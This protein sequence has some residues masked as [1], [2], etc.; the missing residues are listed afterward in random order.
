MAPIILRSFS[1]RLRGFLEG[2]LFADRGSPRLHRA[3]CGGSRIP[4]IFRRL[5][6][7][8][9]LLSEHFQGR[10]ESAPLRNRA[11]GPVAVTVLPIPLAGRAAATPFA[12]V[13][14]TASLFRRW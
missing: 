13:Q 11:L 2:K 3:A 4:G 1:E 6:A 7:A 10:A 8:S 9:G 5:G 14:P 12:T